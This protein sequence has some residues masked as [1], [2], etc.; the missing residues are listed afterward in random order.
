MLGFDVG[1]IPDLVRHGETGL[2][3]PAGDVEG[4]RRMIEFALRNP[5]KLK[6]MGHAGR[7]A[8]LRESQPAIQAARYSDVFSKVLRAA[9]TCQPTEER[10]RA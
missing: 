6:E 4:L 9:E 3:A 5:I 8:V 1:G 10:V 7:E 2:L